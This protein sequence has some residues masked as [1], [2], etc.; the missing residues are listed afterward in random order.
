MRGFQLL[1]SLPVLVLISVVLLVEGLFYAILRLVVV[2]QEHVLFPVTCCS[3]AR[4]TRTRLENAKDWH[5]WLIAAKGLDKLENRDAWKRDPKSR[6]YDYAI[7]QKIVD[8]MEVLIS[9]TQWDSQEREDDDENEEASGVEEGQEAERGDFVPTRRVRR[10]TRD[11]SVSSESSFLVLSRKNAIELAGILEH[12]YT[13]N[14]LGT[15][16]AELYWQTHFQTK[17]LIEKFVELVSRSTR[18]LCQ[19]Q[20][21]AK[22]KAEFLTTAKERIGRTALCLSG[23]GANGYIHF[24]VLF[25]FLAFCLL[26]ESMV[27]VFYLCF[28]WFARYWMPDACQISSPG[29]HRER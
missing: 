5:S 25:L 10:R 12:V 4:R 29:R 21:S 2:F 26:L 24:G 11:E 28:R 7:V 20:L 8:R 16:N 23:G 14:L 27:N 22:E 15:Q 1:L 18:L 3:R 6:F 17:D 9:P 19:S 13:K